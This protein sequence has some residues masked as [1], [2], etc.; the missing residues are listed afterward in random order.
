MKNKITVFRR[1]RNRAIKEFHL[2]ER[3]TYNPEY[4]EGPGA[5]FKENF[6]EGYRHYAHNLAK[7]LYK[8]N[9]VQGVTIDGYI[10]EVEIS[11]AFRWKKD[12]IQLRVKLAIIQFLKSS[13]IPEKLLPSIEREKD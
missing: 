2:R 10:V 5:I 7:N 12:A 11:R 1:N 9:G 3:I 13:L 4:Y 8:I 6:E